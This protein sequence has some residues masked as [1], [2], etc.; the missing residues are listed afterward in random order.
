M[1]HTSRPLGN[2]GA[3][4]LPSSDDRTTAC[5]VIPQLPTEGNC[6]PPIPGKFLIAPRKP[7]AEGFV[8]DLP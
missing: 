1:A 8:E 4:M 3:T 6:G 5:F 7:S 2:V